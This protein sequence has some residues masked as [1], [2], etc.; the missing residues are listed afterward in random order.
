MWP[1]PLTG[2]PGSWTRHTFSWCFTILWSLIQIHAIVKK[3]W[4]RHE[5]PQ[6]ELWPLSVTLTLDLGTRE[7]DATHLL[8]VLYNSVKFDSNPFNNTE[9]MAET[10]NVTDERT[11]ERTDE[12]TNGR[13][14]R[15]CNHYMPP[16]LWGG[17]KIKYMLKY[18]NAGVYQMSGPPLLFK[19]TLNKSPNRSVN[20]VV[21]FCL[22]MNVSITNFTYRY[23]SR[24]CSDFSVHF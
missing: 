13:T 24:Q 3:L 22:I 5:T 16:T 18:T 14:D 21:V 6:F 7:L 8:M 4:L 2:G 23:L 19:Y 11:N 12:R 17:I 15:Q 9:V 10:R 20:I 1:W